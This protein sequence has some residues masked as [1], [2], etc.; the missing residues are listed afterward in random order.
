MLNEAEIKTA[1]SNATNEELLELESDYNENESSI[2]DSLLQIMILA[3][4]Q[5][6]RI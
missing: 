5:K 1:L 6:R 4:K 2:M 3:E